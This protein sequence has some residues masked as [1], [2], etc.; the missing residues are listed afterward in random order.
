MHLYTGFDTV[1]PQRD[2]QTDGQKTH[3]NVAHLYA[4]ST[5]ICRKRLIEIN[6]VF[7]KISIFI[8]RLPA[9]PRELATILQTF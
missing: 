5:E 7:I 8:K 1:P 6:V 2:I 3:I 9:R 4:D